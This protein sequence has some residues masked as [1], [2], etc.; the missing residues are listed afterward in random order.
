[1][2]DDFSDSEGVEEAEMYDMM[3]ESTSG[4]NDMTEEEAFDTYELAFALGL[5]EEIGL[6]EAEAY[7][8]AKL[9]AETVIAARDPVSIKEAR[10]MGRASKSNFS[11]LT[12]QP[13]C[14]FEQWIKDVC[15][16]RKK[17]SDPIGG[18]NSYGKEY[19]LYAG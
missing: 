12:G 3:Q 7:E 8:A 6:E 14:L 11:A 9:D 5:G 4:D 17:V 16:G 19:D 15:A 1:M 18:D 10:A 13:K 2:S